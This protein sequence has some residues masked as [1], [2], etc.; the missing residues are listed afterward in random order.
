MGPRALKKTKGGCKAALG[1]PELFRLVAV[2]VMIVITVSIHRLAAGRI[3]EQPANIV[4]VMTAEIEH[5]EQRS[6]AIIS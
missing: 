1:I 5:V 6:G 2:V 4:F 3:Q